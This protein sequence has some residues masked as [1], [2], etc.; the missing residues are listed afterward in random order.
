MTYAI[1]IL[2]LCML[3][4]IFCSSAEA[5]SKRVT[6]SWVYYHFDGSSFQPGPASD[7][8]A[9]LAVR[10]QVQPVVTQSTFTEMTAPPLSEKN[11]VI[12][13]ICYFQSSGGKLENSPAYLPCPDTPLQ[14]SSGGKQIVTVKTDQDGYFI[15]VL[16]A[17]H[18]SIGSG[19]FTADITVDKGVTTLVPLRA[20]KRM[21]D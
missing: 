6:D 1:R 19:P 14:I 18:Y 8:R 20:G 21:V 9:F 15:V 10:N 13:G 16:E 12:A 5:F 2:T 4:G 3:C 7:G 17:G 11:G